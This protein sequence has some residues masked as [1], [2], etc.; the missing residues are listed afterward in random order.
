MKTKPV[1]GDHVRVY[2]KALKEVLPIALQLQRRSALA[3]SFNYDA[4]WTVLRVDPLPLSDSLVWL[5]QLVDGKE[6]HVVVLSSQ[7]KMS[8]NE[9]NTSI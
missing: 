8:R 3:H 5:S 2:E 1:A 4:E 6:C 7:L 9:T